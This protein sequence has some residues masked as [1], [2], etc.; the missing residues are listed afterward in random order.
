MDTQQAMDI[1]V[2]ILKNN[3]AEFIG[4]FGS[5]AR[6]DYTQG[7]DF[8]LL[9]R[10][11]EPKSIIEMIGLE[12]ALSERIGSKVHIITE[13]SLNRHVAPYILHDLQPAYEKRG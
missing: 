10:F 9:A 2:P 8:D 6:G 4:L 11:S 13:R 3:G 7:S 1:I 12:R 5:R